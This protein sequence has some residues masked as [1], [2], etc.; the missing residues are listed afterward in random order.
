MILSHSNELSNTMNLVL[1]LSRLKES[2]F[3]PSN[4]LTVILV[5]LHGWMAAVL[6]HLCLCALIVLTDTVK[7]AQYGQL[8]LYIFITSII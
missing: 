4:F 5:A 6:Q 1:S 7:N 8:H 3:T 2:L